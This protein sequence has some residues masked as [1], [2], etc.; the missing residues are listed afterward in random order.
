MKYR[1][2]SVQSEHAFGLLQFIDTY[3]ETWR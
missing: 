3:S 2:S 1:R